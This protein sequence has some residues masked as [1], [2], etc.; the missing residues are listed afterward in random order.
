MMKVI[1]VNI[2]TEKGKIKHPVSQIEIIENGVKDDAH[3]G[4]VKR[5]VSLL[6]QEKIDRF[7]NDSGGRKFMPGEFAEN[8]TF[9][10]LDQDQVS[11]LDRFI[12]GTADLEVT[13]IGKECHGTKCAIFNEIGKCVMPKEGIFCKVIKG[14][15][16]K[17]GDSIKY[18][19]FRSQ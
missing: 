17:A 13:Q 14:G 4:V 10:G 19:K 8:I 7:S 2:S 1:S 11:V 3:F 5:E 15:T 9:S 16:I 6:S 18:I 12:I